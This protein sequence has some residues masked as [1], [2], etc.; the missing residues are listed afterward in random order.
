M[1]LERASI[2]SVKK[3]ILILAE[4]GF[5][6]R[7]L[8]LGHFVDEVSQHHD[9]LFAVQDPEDARLLVI[10]RDKPIKLI[11]FPR[12]PY[13]EIRDKW[14]RLLSWDN[15]IYGIRLAKRN[16]KSLEIQT[17]LFEGSGKKRIFS[18]N[19]LSVNIGKI[20]QKLGLQNVVENLYLNSYI[21]NKEIT[22]QWIE[23]LQ[24]HQPNLVLSSMLSHSLRLRCSTDLPVVVAAHSLS[25]PTCTLIQSWDNLSSKISVLPNW[26]KAYFTWSYSM[27]K[28]LIDLNPR[29]SPKTVK[30][31]GSPQYDFHNDNS[32]I[33]SREDFLQKMGLDFNRPYI[34]IG[35]GTSRWMPDEMDKIIQLVRVLH[36][37]KPDLQ[38]VI[39]LHPKDQGER[40]SAY[41]PILNEYGVFLQKTSPEKHMDSGGFIPPADFYRD[42]IN[43]ISH[44]ACVINSSSSLTVDAA[45]FNK[46]VICIAYDVKHDSLFPEGRSWAY[47]QS[48]HYQRL[49]ASGGVWVV[50]SE[51]E[52]ITA[53]DTYLNDPSL[54]SA[55]REKLV[56][57]VA[58]NVNEKA[59]IRL[60][61]EVGNLV[62]S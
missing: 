46:P 3:K 62:T 59:G 21:K 53:I 50:R 33:S 57:T 61:K 12:E 43:I 41:L 31:V 44:S 47:S 52:C 17:R 58:D 24:H 16:S 2:S 18:W 19:K 26:V 28:E 36:S 37:V 25:I 42:Q 56:Q 27:S 39:R 51:A 35:T 13:E 15:W 4:T 38:S 40:W 60:A 55:E 9:I 10:I 20:L 14:R 8:L 32:L 45:I 11:T 22:R 29:I 23:I 34:V 7:N 49:V 1:T 30:V 54:H 5:I 6:I 48:V